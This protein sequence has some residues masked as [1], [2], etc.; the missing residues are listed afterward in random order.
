MEINAWYV[1]T[2]L[3]NRIDD[4]PVLSEYIRA[5]TSQPKEDLFYFHEPFNY[6]M[7]QYEL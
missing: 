2:E 4:A 6:I 1:T 3:T 5:Y 7:E